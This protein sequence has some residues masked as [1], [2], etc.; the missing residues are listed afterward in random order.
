MR[1]T[2]YQCW[3]ELAF[4]HW[5]ADPAAVAAL[6]PPGLEIDTFDGRAWVGI[7][8]LTMRDV[9]PRL[10]PALPG[11]SHF[12]E[13]NVRT[14]VRHGDEA[15]VWFFSLD[16]AGA[17]AV[18][19]ARLTWS[20]PYHPARMA[21]RRDGD[22]IAY[23]SRRAYGA[24][25]FAARY[26]VGAR[27]ETAAPGTFEHFAV[28]RYR[29]YAHR[30][31]RLHT[32]EV[33]HRPYPLHAAEVLDLDETVLRAAGLPAGDGQPHALFSPGVEVGLGPRTRVG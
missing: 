6:L 15:G 18:A 27:I 3:R 14:Y 9:R 20:L 19:V 12:L 21:T 31:G 29:L 11:I 7:V 10:A 8:P 22:V 26:R 30:G 28:E 24:A 13:L 16:A 23:R 25:A 1:I 17:V 33:R 4:L 5:P 2:G 32:G